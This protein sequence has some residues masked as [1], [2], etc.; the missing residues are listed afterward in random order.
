MA[1]YPV[2]RVGDGW[3]IGEPDRTPIRS[4][5]EL[6]EWLAA[7]GHATYG[8]FSDLIFES[9]EDEADFRAML[10]AN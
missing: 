5:R 8:V 6:D 10:A 4:R 9:D 1:Q 3:E 7:R 2:W